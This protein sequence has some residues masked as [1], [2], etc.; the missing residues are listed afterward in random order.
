MEQNGTDEPTDATG[1]TDKQLAALPYIVAAPTLAEGARLATIGRTTLY[2]WMED[3]G[4]RHALETTRSEAADLARTELE[5]LML[6]SVLV[7]AEALEDPAPP[8][9]L[10]AAHAAMTLGLRAIDL[11]EL[12]RRLDSLDD[13]LSILRHKQPVFP[14][15]DPRRGR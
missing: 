12:R 11:K 13:A 1:L 4:F 8:V 6:K 2:R 9:R 7:L 5:G 10:R 15:I 14:F 3:P